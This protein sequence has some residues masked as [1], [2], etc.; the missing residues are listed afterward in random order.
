LTRF[1]STSGGP[2]VPPATVSTAL[3][4]IPGQGPFPRGARVTATIRVPPWPPGMG[5]LAIGEGAV[6]SLNPSVATLLRIDPVTN[7]VAKQIPVDAYAD[8]AVGDGSI[9]LTNPN[10]NTVDRIDLETYRV[11]KTIHVGKNPLG[12]AVTPS[13]VWV[14]NAGLATP[15]IP[16]LSRIDPATNKV[17]ATIR[18]GPTSACCALHM[19]VIVA[20]GAVWTVVPQA[21][22]AVRVDPA[23]KRKTAFRLGYPPCAY[24]AANAVAVWTT[25]G[26][27]ADVVGRFD[28]RTHDLTKL[29]EPHP[30]GLKIAFGHVWVVSLDAANV[31][32]I[33][34]L[35]NQVV[36]RLPIG[37]HPIH[38]AV[39]FGSLWVLDGDGRIL[40]VQPAP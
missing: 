21:N 17:V 40:R 25:G 16:S 18:L 23:T 27:C 2:S 29:V 22:M 19:G 8:F 35:T 9:W 34:P 1:S 39:G 13:A 20:A 4:Q 36:A 31:D 26:A 5:G 33:D 14:A 24:L 38:L 37:G 28:V 30:I 12:I 10:A 7:S 6:W 32:Q 15:D 3:L 11:S